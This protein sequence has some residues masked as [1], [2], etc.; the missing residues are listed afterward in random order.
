MYRHPGRSYRAIPFPI[1]AIPF[2]G[3]V[4]RDAE[5][6]KK[7][8]ELRQLLALSRSFCYEFLHSRYRRRLRILCH[9]AKMNPVASSICFYA[10]QKSF[11]NYNEWSLL[12]TPELY[13]S[14]VQSKENRRST[15]EEPEVNT[16][17]KKNNQESNAQMRIVVTMDRAKRLN[18]HEMVEQ[19]EAGERE[20]NWPSRT[21]SSAASIGAKQRI[22]V[23]SSN[24]VDRDL[25]LS[26]PWPRKFL[27]SA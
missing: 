7:T 24:D 1:R 25:L 20:R 12:E 21:F 27:Q 6:T 5:E 16:T 18:H 3:P 17:N 9:L 11:S 15:I 23:K 2:S 4:W 13:E 8:C 22:M 19:K 14:T 26:N 10:T